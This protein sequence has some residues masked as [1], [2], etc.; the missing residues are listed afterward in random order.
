[1]IQCQTGHTPQY[2]DAIIGAASLDRAMD[3][4]WREVRAT[5][6]GMISKMDSDFGKV[7]NR[8]KGL[9]LWDETVTL[10]F[11][12]HGEWLGD[13]GLIE[14]WP[15]GLSNSLT[16]DPLII[17]GGGLPEGKVFDGMV[18]MVDLVPTLLQ[19]ATT[20]ETYMHYGESLVDV[21]H[22]L[23]RGGNT[24]EAWNKTYSF[25]EG[26]FLTREE[27]LVE[28]A[29]F[30]YD[31]KSQLQHN[32]TTLVGMATSMRSKEWTYVY[33]I[34]EAD[35][36]YSRAD[37]PGERNNLAEVP[38]YQNIKAELKGEMMRWIISTSDVIP[39]YMDDRTPEVALPSPNEQYAMRLGGTD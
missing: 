15:S 33:C 34:Y 22:A 2:V 39:W 10:F 28:Y 37:D 18:E 27:P 38:E 7:V 11:T 4:K 12:H 6:Y 20:N 13:Y 5:Y 3:D 30:P 19:L 36:L 26:G 21:I 1:M 16:H 23:G 17:G 35:E 25:T 31:I 24:S 9:G 14:K 8:T 32:Q 29:S